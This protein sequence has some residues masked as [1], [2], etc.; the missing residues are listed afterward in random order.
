MTLQ[1]L[2]LDKDGFLVNLNDWSPTIA[3]EIAAHENIVLTPE[4]WEIIDLVRKFYDEF[5]LSPVNRVLVKTTGVKLGQDK[6]NSIYLMQ[7]FPGGPAKI[8]C[9]IAGLPKPNNCL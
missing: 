9:K 5:G 1:D 8:A 7:L 6:G 3:E 2:P 4:H